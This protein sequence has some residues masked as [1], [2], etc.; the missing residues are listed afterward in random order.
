[1]HGSH[2]G[3]LVFQDDEVPEQNIL[4]GVG[5]GGQRPDVRAGFGAHRIIGRPLGIM[6]GKLAD[7]YS[8]MR[9]CKAY[10]YAMG[11]ACDRARMPEAVRAAQGCRRMLIGSELFDEAK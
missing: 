1:M 4:G 2:T 7:M 5:K 10:I 6:Q 3:E 11:Q 8:T 9:A